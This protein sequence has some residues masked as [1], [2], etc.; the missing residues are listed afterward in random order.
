MKAD[1]LMSRQLEDQLMKT[2]DGRLMK[3]WDAAELISCEYV[4]NMNNSYYTG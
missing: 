3:R 4:L 1:G 2:A